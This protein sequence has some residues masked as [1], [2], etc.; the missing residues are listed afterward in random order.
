MWL[1][2]LAIS[3]SW[4][5]YPAASPRPWAAYSVA[6]SHPWATFPVASSHLWAAFPMAS[7]CL[8]AACPKTSSC[9]CAACPAATS[10]LPRASHWGQCLRT[11]P[12]CIT[13]HPRL[14]GSCSHFA[15]L[16]PPSTH[17]ARHTI[18]KCGS[19]RLRTLSTHLGQRPG[20]LGDFWGRLGAV[21]WEGG[22]VRILV[23]LV[24]FPYV[25]LFCL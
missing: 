11:Q 5:A 20:T 10:Y 12:V 17:P 8:W 25:I 21:R 15:H 22:T 2:T 13:S 23:S 19:A 3:C 14:W 4:A 1:A 24:I 16:R 18:I 9:L 6:S 7:S